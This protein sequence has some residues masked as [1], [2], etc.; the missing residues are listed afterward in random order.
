M[1]EITVKTNGVQPLAHVLAAVNPQDLNALLIDLSRWGKL[2][3]MLGGRGWRCSIEVNVNTTG[4]K[5]EVA[6]EGGAS[7]PLEATL[8]LRDRLRVALQTL[9]V[10]P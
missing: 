4:A 3:L 7:S 1:S 2:F 5:F 9:G 10:K 6:S 8:D